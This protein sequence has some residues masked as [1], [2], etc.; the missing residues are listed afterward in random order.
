MSAIF[1]NVIIV[2]INMDNIII[3]G[4]ITFVAHLAN[5]IKV[6]KRLLDAGMQVNPEKCIWFQLTITYL[7]FLISHKGIKP[8]PE[9]IQSFLY[10]QHPQTQKE[11]RHFV[12][13]MVNF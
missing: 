7:G 11:V 8:Q 9:K 1:C 10:M 6:L 4:Y 2:V 5:V 13:M 3:F 12:G